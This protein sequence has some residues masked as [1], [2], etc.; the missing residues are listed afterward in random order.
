MDNKIK[1]RYR[2]GNCGNEFDEPDIIQE[3]MG[4]FWGAPAYQTFEVC[5][6]CGEEIIEE[7]DDGDK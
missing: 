7:E 1:P 2:C 3:C 4:E 5:P 6:Y